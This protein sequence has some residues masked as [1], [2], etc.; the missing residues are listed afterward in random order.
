MGAFALGRS[1]EELAAARDALASFLAGTDLPGL[2]SE[3]EVFGPARPYLAR[4][5]AI[6]LPFDAVVGAAD[7]ALSRA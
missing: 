5:P 6:L 7:A 2:A 4:H 3:F 1:R